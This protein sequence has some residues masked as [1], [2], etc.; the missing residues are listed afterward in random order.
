MEQ[1]FYDN[2]ERHTRENT[3]FRRVLFTGKGSQL[4]LMC[5]EAGDALGLETHPQ[6]DQF[7][8]FE[9]GVGKAIVAGKEYAICDGMTVIVPMGTEHN[10]VNLS[11]TEP[12][13]FYTIYS[14]AHHP[15]G[16]VHR[17]KADADAAEKHEHE[18]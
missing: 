12:L 14:P 6:N 8:R 13:K 7:F 16:T 18:E 11:E 15:D 4:V 5:V 17:T 9:S 10:I 2:I 1:A 3:D